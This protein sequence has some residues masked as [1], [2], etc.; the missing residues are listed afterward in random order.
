MIR[1][2]LND[3]LG[4]VMETISS[5]QGEPYLLQLPNAWDGSSFGRITSG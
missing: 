5:R 3:I 1:R 2:D 4:C